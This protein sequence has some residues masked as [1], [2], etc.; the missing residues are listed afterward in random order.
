MVAFK[1]KIYEQLQSEDV[2]NSILNR[3]TP[4]S[5]IPFIYDED[6]TLY[7]P[8]HQQA[9]IEWLTFKPVNEISVSDANQ[10]LAKV[11]NDKIM[12]F[13]EHFSYLFID[14]S[15]A[16]LQINI[17]NIVNDKE[18]LKG[19]LQWMFNEV[20]KV[21]IHSLKPIDVTLYNEEDIESSFDQFALIDSVAEFEHAFDIKL[22]IRD[23]ESEEI[24]RAI[25]SNLVFYKR[26]LNNEFRYAHISFYKMYAQETHAIQP[27]ENMM[28]GKAIEGI[29][30]SVPSMK[31]EE[32]YKS[33]FGIKAYSMFAENYLTSIAYYVN[34]LAVNVKNG[35]ND[36]YRKGE[37][38][39][40]RTATTD[41]ELLERIFQSSYW[42]TF[43]DPHV[44]LE[45]FNTYDGN[46]VVIHYS[47]QY[48]SSSR[49]DAITVTDKS[50]QYFAVIKEFL[51]LKGVEG[52]AENVD[53][54]IK[55]FNTFNGEWLLRIIG[56]KGHYDREKL[57]IISAI[58]YSLSYLDH[59][60]VLWVPISLEE[61][62]RVAGAVG[63]NKSEGVFTAKTLALKAVI[64]T[65]YY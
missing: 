47:D 34:E 43:V 37:A 51:Q 53:A 63:F 35:A 9:A 5:L 39:F 1:L 2:D 4:E 13:K 27:M 20:K 23:M 60:N 38:I 19:I 21:G 8:E 33:G 50:S 11:V 18:V 14:S 44:D 62:L 17:I 59:P 22:N 6:D 57:S 36:S 25:R 46:L 28:T 10:Y 56:S 7:K 40:S 30:S 29:Y 3:L 48:S 12:Q 31:D 61:V 15:D 49:Y 45:F 65:I 42:V 24:L 16:P 64:V 26:D 52:T 58:K 54:T 32:N 41:E 55:A